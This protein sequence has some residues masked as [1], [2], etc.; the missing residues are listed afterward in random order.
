MLVPA[1]VVVWI[2]AALALDAS[3]SLS[4]QRALGAATWA[5]LGWA[6]W[7]EGKATR[8][9]VA[10]AVVFATAVEYTAAPLLGIYSYRLDNVPAF[11]PPG[12]GLVYLGALH[13]GRS[14]SF[15]AARRALVPAT[16]AAAAGW[17]AWG[18]LFSSRRD[19]LGALLFLVLAR[20]LLAGR[21]PLVYAGAF[22]ITT[23]LEFLGTA[24]GTWTWAAHDP[25]GLLGIGNPPSGIA[26]GYCVFDAA[27]LALAPA[28]LQAAARL[29]ARLRLLERPHR[30]PV[31]AELRSVE[32]G[33]L[34][35]AAPDDRAPAAVDAIGNAHPLVVAD[36]G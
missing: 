24:V 19:L 34:A 29:R 14:A 5:L 22:A 20:F 1:V 36:A 33:R 8:A 4:Q 28:L 15:A 26:G 27:A 16:L 25:T 12:H 21:A 35:M 32:L 23:Y 18:A 11:V 31:P 2:G 17:A 3:A 7:R 6:L 10:I 30:E 13:L 9:Q